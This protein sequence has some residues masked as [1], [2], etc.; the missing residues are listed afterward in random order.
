[1]RKDGFGTLTAI[2]AY[3][4][5]AFPRHAQKEVARRLRCT[6]GQAALIVRGRVPAALRRALIQI[7]DR[8][9]ARNQEHLRR[10]HAEVR[11]LNEDLVAR[12]QDSPAPPVGPVSDA[13]AGASG[14]SGRLKD[15]ARWAPKGFAIV[16]A[17][18]RS[19]VHH[20]SPLP[21]GPGA[22][23]PAPGA[24]SRRAGSRLDRGPVFRGSIVVIKGESHEGKREERPRRGA[25]AC[26]RDH[27][28]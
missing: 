2:T 17:E 9:I 6:E 1:M 27:V 11:A 12:M 26:G 23:S 28:G 7:L 24:F 16:F 21:T 15:A 8:A 20:V 25:G 5:A 10:L 22:A 4:S 14:A 18:A 19:G 13:A 3:V